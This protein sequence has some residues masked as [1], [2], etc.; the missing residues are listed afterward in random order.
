[1]GVWLKM[2]AYLSAST[3]TILSKSSLGRES[4]RQMHTYSG[5]YLSPGP[6]TTHMHVQSYGP[7]WRGPREICD[8]NESWANFHFRCISRPINWMTEHN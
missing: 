8:W 3:V 7:V 5:P 1:M 4:H 2:N 6:Y